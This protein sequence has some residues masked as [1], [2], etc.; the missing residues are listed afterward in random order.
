LARPGVPVKLLGDGEA[1]KNLT[2]KV[3]RVSQGARTRLEQAG[4]SVEIVA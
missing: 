1:P 4:G 2:V 3:Q